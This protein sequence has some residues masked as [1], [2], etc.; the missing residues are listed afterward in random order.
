MTAGT[1]PL[2]RARRDARRRAARRTCL[3]CGTAHALRV[4]NHPS[5]HVVV[6][7]HCG[8]VRL[9]ARLLRPA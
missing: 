2:S 6:C 9:A 5:G 3:T 8:D 7:I 1:T 4:V